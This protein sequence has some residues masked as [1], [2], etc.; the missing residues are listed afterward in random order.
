MRQSVA[1]VLECEWSEVAPRDTVQPREG[2]GRV[3]VRVRL[4]EKLRARVKSEKCHVWSHEAW[5]PTRPA[6]DTL[7]ARFIRQSDFSACEKLRQVG[8]DWLADIISHQ[9]ARTSGFAGRCGLVLSFFFVLFFSMV[10]VTTSH[11]PRPSNHHGKKNHSRLFFQTCLTAHR[12]FVSASIPSRDLRMEQANSQH[13]VLG[14][15]LSRSIRSS[16]QEG[17]T[18][19]SKSMGSNLLSVIPVP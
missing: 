5:A 14:A 18:W 3:R 10:F 17:Q 4:T 1:A 9:L 19:S 15:R 16:S 12:M 6:V 8:A 7:E 2:R 13:Y 11:P